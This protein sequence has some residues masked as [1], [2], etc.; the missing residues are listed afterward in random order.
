VPKLTLTLGGICLFVYRKTHQE[1]LVA[2]MPRD[3][4]HGHWPQIIKGE[5]D[6]PEGYLAGTYD[7]RSTLSGSTSSPPIPVTQAAHFT[8]LTGN[9]G[10]VPSRMFGAT[11]PDAVRARFFLP[12]PNEVNWNGKPVKIETVQTTPKPNK[13]SIS[14][15]VD[16]VY[17]FSSGFTIDTFD[18]QGQPKQFSVDANG[19]KK[20]VIA[21]VMSPKVN[22]GFYGRKSLIPHATLFYDVL[23]GCGD[24]NS[25][26]LQTAEDYD[27]SAPIRLFYVNPVE[28]II[29]TGCEEGMQGTPGCE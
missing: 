21:N 7:W 11:K 5:N 17:D 18:G 23:D 28:C 16:L 1:G 13:D 6:P 26:A 27:N 20:L 12:W 25:P 4:M 15:D 3:L 8:N 19:N 22:R 2:L 10:Y 9:R 14:G 29:G 24:F